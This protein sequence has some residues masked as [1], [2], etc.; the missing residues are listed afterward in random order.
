MKKLLTARWIL[1]ALFLVLSGIY[2]VMGLSPKSFAGLTARVQIMPSMV[3]TS[4]GIILFWLIITIVYGRMYCGWICPAGT[5]TDLVSRIRRF[6]PI[7]FHRF[8]YRPRRKV[9]F[10]ILALYLVCMVAGIAIVPAL[11]EPWN[12][13]RNLTGLARPEASAVATLGAGI[14]TGILAG[15]FS[16]LLITVC[17]LLTGRS[18]CTDLCP[19]GTLL[20]LAAS[21]ALWRV[22][23]DPDRCTACLKCEE[24]CPAG[25]VKVVGR[26]V[27]DSRCVRCME[28][29]GRCPEE[30]IRF[31]PNRNRPATP[32]LRRREHTRGG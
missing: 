27:D 26:Y 16:L 23:I 21:N 20:Q 2:L 7:R 19:V 9:R 10:H 22:E 6:M 11:V 31:Q 29:V 5:L 8:R 13:F 3:A 15:L 24:V 28:C 18:L 17:A 1:A 30:A 25:C 12:I 4:I 32:L 14:A